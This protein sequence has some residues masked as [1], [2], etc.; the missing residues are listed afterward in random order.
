MVSSIQVIKAKYEPN[1]P[2][3]DSY[4]GSCKIYILKGMVIYLKRL[5]GEK[6]KIL[7]EMASNCQKLEITDPVDKLGLIDEGVAV[8]LVGLDPIVAA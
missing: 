1:E 2:C 5:L 4:V 3:F 8:A 6:S 7:H